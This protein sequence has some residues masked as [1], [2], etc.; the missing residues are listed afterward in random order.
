MAKAAEILTGQFTLVA[1]NVPYLGRG[2]QD[3]TLKEHLEQNFP[4]SKA[5]LAT[6][7]VERCMHF[8][9]TGGSQAVVTP[10]NWLFLTTYTKLREALLK[11]R[12]WNVIARLGANAFQDMNW[13]AATTALLI[14]SN[15]EAAAEHLI[16]GVDA[17]ADKRQEIKAA[18]LSGRVEA[19]IAV[20]QQ[21]DQIHNPDAR[22]TIEPLNTLPALSQY[23][24]A[25]NGSHGGDSPR[26]RLC[27][28][29]LQ[30]VTTKWRFFQGTVEQTQPYSGREH[31]FSRPDDGAYHRESP[32]ARI[33]G[34][35]VIGRQGVVV[36]MMR[37]LPV[38][39]YSGDLFDISC[40]P[41]V[42]FDL[43]NLLPIW[44]FCSSGSYLDEVRKIDQKVNVTNATLAKVPFDLAHWKKIATEKFP[45]G[46]PKPFSSESTQW[47]FNGHPL[48][49][50][51]PLHVAVARLVGY[52]WPRQTGSSFIDCPALGPD[53]LEALA[54]EDGIV[55]LAPVRGEASALE[56]LRILLATALG[57]EWS[58][59]KERELLLATAV[60]N[61]AK[62]PETDLESWLRSSFFSEHCKLFHS[63]PFIWQIWDGNA[64]GFSALVNYHKLAAPNGLSVPRPVA[65]SAAI[66]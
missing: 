60:D 28:W 47:L 17:S 24:D 27:F 59:S 18:M 6:A 44:A 19:H 61:N 5:D 56:R 57:E 46:L 20:V 51:Q 66:L 22:L 49:A 2:K 55:C 48:G 4:S 50:D 30:E 34:D 40:T 12:T 41:L 38:T 15:T 21:A 37:I 8:C 16:F 11:N 32:N 9:A 58:S 62:K 36:S 10:Q 13:W 29:E 52:E 23:V 43:A 45:H 26:H 1:T 64:N 53:G 31:I 33:Q 54:D 65:S 39:L 14:L 42:P 7:F 25:P 63:R 3:D 35:N